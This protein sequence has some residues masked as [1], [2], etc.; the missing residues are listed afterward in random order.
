MLDNRNRFFIIL[1]LLALTFSVF[2]VFVYSGNVPSVS[3]KS[4]ALY[5]PSTKS[6]LYT[7][8][9]NQRLPMA[10]TTKIMT[11][12]LAIENLDPEEIIEIDER[13]VG[14]EGSSVYLKSGEAM[15]AI[16]LVYS[17]LLQSAND[18]AA[19]L[20]LR[21]SGSIEDFAILMNEKAESLGLFDTSFKNPHGLD[22]DGHYTTAHD[23]AILTAAALE[24]ETFKTITST[25]KK[26]LV[27]SDMQRLVVN[28]NKLLKSYDGCI[29]V[30]TGYTK[31]SGRCLSSAAERGGEVLVAI[32]INAPDD[33]RD[34]KVMLDYGWSCRK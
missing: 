32:T 29:G 30:K 25:Y 26:T 14:I 15:R 7:K 4:A 16:D 19:A 28:H 3:A 9:E 10:S 17:L 5:E 23:L 11:A 33:W 22:E 20:A 8:N 1:L 34:H 24:N 27:S 12:L 6:F 18:A 13:A 31:K 2:T 21:I